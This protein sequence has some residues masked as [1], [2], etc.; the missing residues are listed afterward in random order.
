MGLRNKRTNKKEVEMKCV[1]CG[2]DND[3]SGDALE[4]EVCWK[5]DG[6]DCYCP[7]CIVNGVQDRSVCADLSDVIGTDVVRVENSEVFD[8]KTYS[9]V[10]KAFYGQKMSEEFGNVV[11]F[12]RSEDSDPFPLDLLLSF[13]RLRELVKA[14]K[15][16][17][18][19]AEWRAVAAKKKKSWRWF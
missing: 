3:F 12:S 8:K 19:W 9:F 14:R 17:E 18:R 16:E 11:E 13:E 2:R 5:R 15:K 6:D 4:R 1:V 10:V 7:K